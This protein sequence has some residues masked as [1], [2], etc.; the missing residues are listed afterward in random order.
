[1][2][3]CLESLEA[4]QDNLRWSQVLNRPADR[5]FLNHPTGKRFDLRLFSAEPNVVT[6]NRDCNCKPLSH[7]RHS[8]FRGSLPNINQGCVLEWPVRNGHGGLTLHRQRGSLTAGLDSLTSKVGE[9][10]PGVVV[11]CGNRSA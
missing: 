8:H 3:L 5:V 11:A 4:V 7:P 1:M 9:S 10:R 6:Q 2:L